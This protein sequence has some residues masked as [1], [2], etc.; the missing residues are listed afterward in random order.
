[1][2]EPRFVTRVLSASIAGV[3][4]GASGPVGAAACAATSDRRETSASGAPQAS[5]HTPS[6]GMKVVRVP[7]PLVPTVSAGGVARVGPVNEGPGITGCRFAHVMFKGTHVIGTRDL[8]SGPR[9]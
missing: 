6:N 5:A 3:L 9:S 1:M 8:D 4:A 7:R 2:F